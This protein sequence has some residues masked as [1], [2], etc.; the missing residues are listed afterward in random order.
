MQNGKFRPRLGAID[1]RVGGLS[2]GLS[3][4]CRFFLNLT[5]KI[6]PAFQGNLRA[7][8][9]SWPEDAIAALDSTGWAEGEAKTSTADPD[10]DDALFGEC[11]AGLQNNSDRNRS[12]DRSRQ[13]EWVRMRMVS[14]SSGDANMAVASN[15]KRHFFW[16]ALSM[17]LPL[18]RVIS[19][20]ELRRR[21][22]PV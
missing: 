7:I 6:G 21:N 14:I 19:L 13:S 9:N 5:D 8:V 11:A 10:Y 15:T 1:P 16:P 3:G 22:L 4:A 12:N 18:A 17:F 2:L 20:T